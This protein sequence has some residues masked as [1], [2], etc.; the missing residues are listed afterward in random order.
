VLVECPS[1]A[2]EIEDALTACPACGEV[3]EDAAPVAAHPVQGVTAHPSEAAADSL[4]A[5]RAALLAELELLKREIA[6]RR[7]S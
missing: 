5:L 3:R 1:C 6:R 2:L 4:E 7:S